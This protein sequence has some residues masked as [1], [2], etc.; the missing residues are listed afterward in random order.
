MQM[1]LP[2]SK[3]VQEVRE[4]GVHLQNYS[5][6]CDVQVME[7]GCAARRGAR[8]LESLSIE[9]YFCSTTV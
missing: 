6:K 9:M 7:Y 8:A 5:L 1:L 2:G 3:E 4:L